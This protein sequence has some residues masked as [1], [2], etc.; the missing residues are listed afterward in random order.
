MNVSR[1]P[2]CAVKLR[3]QKVNLSDPLMNHYWAAVNVAFDFR[4]AEL[5]EFGGF[6]FSKVNDEN[7]KKLMSRL[8]AFMVHREQRRAENYA[9]ANDYLRAKL[10][11][12]GVKTSQLR[13]EN[14]YWVACEI[15]FAGKVSREGGFTSLLGQI[16]EIT[17]KERAVMVRQNYSRLPAQWMAMKR[18]IGAARAA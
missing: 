5:A 18:A 1:F 16:N 8:E 7:G 4:D 12:Y 9:F 15:L 10:G 13:S 14:D 17:K 11:A 6:D 2:R 3:Y